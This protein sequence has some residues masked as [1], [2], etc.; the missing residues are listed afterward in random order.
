MID[1]MVDRSEFR[2]GKVCWYRN[3]KKTATNDFTC[4]YICII[5]SLEKFCIDNDLLRRN[6]SKL[7]HDVRFGRHQYLN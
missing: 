5:K 1:D 2:C 7:F 3:H 6:L 4:L